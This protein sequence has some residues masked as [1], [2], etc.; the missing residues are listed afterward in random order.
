MYTLVWDGRDDAGS[1]VA[2]G[3]YVYRVRTDR[4]SCSRKM[5]LLK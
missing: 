2:S 5:T 1:Q 4:F 3:I